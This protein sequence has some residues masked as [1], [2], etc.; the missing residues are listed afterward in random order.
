M[1]RQKLEAFREH[2]EKHKRRAV[3]AAMRI[4]GNQQDALELSQEAFAKAFFAFDRYDSAKGAF[5]TWFYRILANTCTTFLR[6][7]ARARKRMGARVPLDG[8]ATTCPSDPSQIAERD[9]SKRALWAAITRL[10]PQHREIITLRHF[11]ELSYQE[12]ADVLGCPLGTVMSR[13]FEARR[14]LR[15]ELGDTQDE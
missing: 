10:A 15:K 8:V 1:R 11:D 3:N 13:L 7:K 2:V 12:I 14:R 4:V 9:E 5:Y 6:R